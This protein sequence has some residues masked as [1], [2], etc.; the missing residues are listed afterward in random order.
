MMIKHPRVVMMQ[1]MTVLK[2]VLLL[3]GGWS[4]SSLIGGKAS[5]SAAGCRDMSRIL[6][7]AHHCL[8]HKLSQERPF[9]TERLSLRSTCFACL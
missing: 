9:F 2:Q 3:M 1:T 7:G 8:C 5:P 6:E 4:F